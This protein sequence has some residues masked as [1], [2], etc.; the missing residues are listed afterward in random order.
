[1]GRQYGTKLTALLKILLLGKTGQ[2]GWEPQRSLAPLCEV[3]SLDGHSTQ[4]C[5]DFPKPDKLAKTV[6][7]YK[8]D[9][10][11]NSAAHTTCYCEYNMVK[12]RNLIGI[13]VLNYFYFKSER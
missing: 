5:G 6:A 1:V 10:I 2:V 7:A 3:L 11:I 9:F 8:P 13:N 12:L 4:H